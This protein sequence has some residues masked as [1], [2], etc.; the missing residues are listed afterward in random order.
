MPLRRVPFPREQCS[1]IDAGCGSGILALT[2]AVL[3]CHP[4]YAFDR[5]P[6]AV[7]VTNENLERNL[8]SG[9]VEVLEAGLEAGLKDRRA[10]ILVANIQADVLMIYAD[11]LVQAWDPSGVMILS[12]ILAKEYERVEDA[13]TGMIQRFHRIEPIMTMKQMGDWVVLVFIAP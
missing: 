9:K 12:G 13:F 4:V 2:A 11:N 5:D 8:L 10:C 3:G 6:L 7:E 1:V